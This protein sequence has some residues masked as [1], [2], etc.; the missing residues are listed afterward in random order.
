MH[1]LAGGFKSF[2]NVHPYLGELIQFDEDMFQMGWNHQQL[3][4]YI[5]YT[6]EN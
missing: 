2:F 3:D 1:I 4:I 6:P 5:Y